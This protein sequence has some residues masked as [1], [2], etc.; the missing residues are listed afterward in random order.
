VRSPMLNP[1]PATD[2]LADSLNSAL[3]A[4]R[5]RLVRLCQRLTGDASAAED[6]AQETLLTAW[7]LR[8]RLSAPE[9][10][11]AWLA[12]IA[13]NHCRRW[14]RTHGADRGRII[15]LHDE[16]GGEDGLTAPALMADDGDPGEAIE[17]DAV[18][19]LARRALALAPE[20]TRDLLAAVYLA[21]ASTSDAARAHGVSDGALRARLMRARQAMRAALAADGDLRDQLED[22][23]LT[24]PATDGWQDSRIWCPF[25]GASYLRYRIDR[26]TGEYAFHCAGGCAGHAVAGGAKRIELVRAVSSPKSLL[27]RHCL[28]LDSDYRT[29]L[30]RGWDSCFLCG[31]RGAFRL[32]TPDETPPGFPTP[33]GIEGFCP[34]CG[35]LDGASA[36]HL[37]LDT[38]EAQR[39]WRRYP[40][41]RA[42]P[43]RAVEHA[44]RASIVTGFEALGAHARLEIV[45][46]ARD[47]TV[48]LSEVSH[49]G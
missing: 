13:R 16:D 31:A 34:R 27:A 33:Y 2:R 45:A 14:A 49:A 28:I 32:V 23:G 37:A 35:Q 26:E 17:R 9:G 40:R 47:Y 19:E 42:L 30:R 21:E 38:P 3:A 1:A 24:L 46:D 41:M 8:D 11:S 29:A 7:R 10:L 5:P 36:W 12:A 48:L 44:G 6:L 22:L 18:A 43:M 4:E 25:C 15:F 39:F 20:A